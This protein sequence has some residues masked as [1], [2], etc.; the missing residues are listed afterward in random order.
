MRFAGINMEQL[1]KE[2]GSPAFLYVGAPPPPAAVYYPH[3]K[4]N[5]M[6]SAADGS[7]KSKSL[8]EE[9]T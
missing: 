3:E 6:V 7:G 8:P 5:E 4:R 2:Y 9:A 1:G